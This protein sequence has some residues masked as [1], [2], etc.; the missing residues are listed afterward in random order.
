MKLF[1]NSLI[2]LRACLQLGRDQNL[3]SRDIY[4]IYW[5]LGGFLLW[6]MG[7][8]I[9]PSLM[10]T[11][12]FT[13]LFLIPSQLNTLRGPSADLWVFPLP[14]SLGQLS[15][16]HFSALRAQFPGTHQTSSSVSSTR[17]A[18]LRPA[19]HPHPSEVCKL[20]PA[21]A[22]VVLTLFLI[23]Q[24]PCP[25]LPGSQSLQTVVSFLHQVFVAAAVVEVGRVNLVR[26]TLFQS[27]LE[28]QRSFE[29]RGYRLSTCYNE[30]FQA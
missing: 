17:T 18:R 7:M 26:I 9:A 22:T 20:S 12:D 1:R 23:S 14:S 11:G 3:L 15:F 6:P 19:P 13:P 28:A 4:L 8:Q 2:L 21:V 29:L 24:G 27:E 16:L 5:E 10:S 30:L 25:A